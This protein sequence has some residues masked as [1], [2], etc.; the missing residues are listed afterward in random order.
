MI[1]SNN[2]SSVQ[3]NKQQNST[4][5]RSTSHGFGRRSCAKRSKKNEK[6]SKKQQKIAT[7]VASDE[8]GCTGSTGSSKRSGKSSSQQTR[9]QFSAH[10]SESHNRF[11][12]LWTHRDDF[13]YAPHPDPGGK[14]QWKTESRYPLSDRK[15]EQGHH[16]YGIRHGDKADYALLDIDKGSPY[17]PSSDPLA[18]Q[19][20][21]AA[22]E[23]LGL[24]ASIK[25]T[26][27][28]S[29]G[30]HIV[31]PFNKV[32][33]SRQVGI[34]VTA[35]LESAGYKVSPGVL[36][37]FPNRKPY[38]EGVPTLF[39]A[40]RLPLQQGSYLLDDDLNPVSSSQLLF[41]QRWYAAKRKN[42]ISTKKLKL[43]IRQKVRYAYKKVSGK[44]SKFL[45]DLN[46]EINLGWTAKG[47]TNRLIGRIVMRTY[48][49]GHIIS[50]STTPLTGR[51]LADEVER[52]ARSL[53]GFDEFCG[54]R[55][56]L[57]KRICEWIRSIMRSHYFPYNNGK[58]PLVIKEGPT[59]NEE[60]REAARERI[61]SAL[62]DL[63]RHNALP[64]GKTARATALRA[65]KVS[66]DTLYKHKDLWHPDYIGASIR[67]VIAAEQKI[68]EL[69][70]DLENLERE[71]SA[72]GAASLSEPTNL[73]EATGR[74]EPNGNASSDADG[75]KIAQKER[76][77]R[78]E[79]NGNASSDADELNNAEKI[80]RSPIPKQL[81]L[82][83]RRTLQAIREKQ[84]ANS[85]ENRARYKAQKKKEAAAAHLAKLKEWAVSGDPVLEG[86][87]NMQ[88]K[89]LANL[90]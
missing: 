34:A 69:D 36:E 67:E 14:P 49:F 31:L 81:A 55:H 40:H 43:T 65:Y 41:V 24:V 12:A 46:G 5:K 53:P 80:V 6:E 56:D 44:A 51:V 30:L 39:N 59:W 27:S 89:R 8:A 25:T 68:A 58:K 28:Y 50:A 74:N 85:Q 61:R 84:Q 87:A 76:S 70:T 2:S 90:M 17:H 60:Q 22:L 32:M 57:R 10:I 3:G 75:A 64:D 42:D 71:A 82:N 20:I 7:S 1:L 88:L 21:C 33:L 13:I 45:N 37:V 38:I 35:V 86:E 11:A 16:I 48:I 54:H 72:E 47:Q 83:I 29:N 78:N 4:H 23:P 52:I 63:C 73:L 66:Q 19:G 18:V 77:G 15:L 26:S 79:P 9:S 62:V